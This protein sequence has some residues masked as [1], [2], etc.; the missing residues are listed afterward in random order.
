MNDIKV[1]KLGKF[2]S[3]VIKSSL[4]KEEFPVLQGENPRL[5]YPFRGLL[6]ALGVLAHG[7]IVASD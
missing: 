7:E 3:A 4:S 6:E 1:P 2:F 5:K